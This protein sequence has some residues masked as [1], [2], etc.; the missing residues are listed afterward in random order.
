[1]Q[2]IYVNISLRELHE[3]FSLSGIIFR[4]LSLWEEMSWVET[5]QWLK[6]ATLEFWEISILS[7]PYHPRWLVLTGWSR[8]KIGEIC[9]YPL[10]QLIKVNTLWEMP[11]VEWINGD[12]WNQATAC[13]YHRLI[14]PLRSV[15]QQ[16]NK[17]GGMS[18]KTE[19]V[20]FLNVQTLVEQP[21][22]QN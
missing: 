2:S 15:S 20:W 8:G 9:I 18:S 19:K 5:E 6:K 14:C 4:C 12:Q 17:H 1:M 11:R 16:N 22:V 10:D 21:G 7:P 3:H 13:K